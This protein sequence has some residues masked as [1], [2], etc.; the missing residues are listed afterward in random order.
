MN[1]KTVAR[2]GRKPIETYT[3]IELD[4]IEKKPADK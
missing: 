3:L 2:K 4:E 1:H